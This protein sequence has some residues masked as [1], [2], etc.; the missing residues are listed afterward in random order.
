MENENNENT[1]S[2]NSENENENSTNESEENT[3][4]ENQEEQTEKTTEEKTEEKKEEI[5]PFQKQL[6][7]RI[8]T[9]EDKMKNPPQQKTGE[10][11]QEFETRLSSLEIATAGEMSEAVKK[12]VE[13]HK[14]VYPDK[15]YK[16]I[17]EMPFIQN[18]IKEE[19]DAKELDD[20]AISPD[21]KNAGQPNK[22]FKGMTITD[23]NKQYDIATEAGAAAYDKWE[24]DNK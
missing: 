8:K 17:K 11:N 15:S 22:N 1:N 18:M 24:A 13:E 9:L 14:K 10:T 5:T 3:S 21:G 16:E 7:G 6:L 12:T 4:N 23:F 19:T 2:Q 20:A